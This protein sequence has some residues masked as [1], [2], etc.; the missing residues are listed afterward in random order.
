ML[1]FDVCLRLLRSVPLGRV[2]FYGEGEMVVLPVNHA[3]DGQHVIFRTARGSKLSAAAEQSLVSFE[4]DDY[5]PETH[6]GWS[7][8]VTGR[9][10]LVYDGEEIQ[11]LRRLGLES[12]TAAAEHPFWVRI[13]PTSV[14]GRRTGVPAQ[15]GL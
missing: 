14:T 15:L 2:V 1:P 8:L 13:L 12:W 7:V 5:D 9:A 10:E 3:M 6:A 11:R 4:A